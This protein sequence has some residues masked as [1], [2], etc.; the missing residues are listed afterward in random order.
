MKEEREHEKERAQ[1]ENEEQEK[2]E[3]GKE[4]QEA[5]EEDEHKNCTLTTDDGF[6]IVQ[7]LQKGDVC[8]GQ[9]DQVHYLDQLWD[10][11]LPH[12][13]IEEDGEA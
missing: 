4:E 13:L 3:E 2:A 11:L 10:L 12:V 6:R 1:E 7:D 5:Y 9:D 8:Y